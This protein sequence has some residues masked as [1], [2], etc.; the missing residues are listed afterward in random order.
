MK[1]WRGRGKAAGWSAVVACASGIHAVNVAAAA[2]RPCVLG[3]ASLPSGELSA[4]T[5]AALAAQ[6]RSDGPWVLALGRQEYRILVVP[7][8]PVQEAE[9]EQSLRWTIA[10]M[11][12]FAPEEANLAWMRIPTVQEL[13]NRPPQLYVMVTRR[14]WIERYARL[15]KDARLALRAIDVRET[16][17]RNLATLASQPGEGVALLRVAPDGIELTISCNGELYLDRFI[18]EI[19]FGHGLPDP[20]AQERMLERIALQV[21]RSLD[22]IERNLSFIEVK[23]L[24]I[25]PLPRPLDLAGL[26]APNLAIPVENLDLADHFD[27]SLTPELREQE[28]QA[29][30]FE[31]LGAA[32]RFSSREEKR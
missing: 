10:G 9:I 12:D 11:I 14:E 2:G 29:L 4:R 8:P 27:F 23:R 16:G 1:F 17:Q 5:L 3:C 24:L 25:A 18:E 6:L 30:Y 32:L 7:E 21:Q 26:I 15:F 13:P 20:E 31:A 22:Y 19:V 28:N